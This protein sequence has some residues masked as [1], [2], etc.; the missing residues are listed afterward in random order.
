M[1]EYRVASWISLCQSSAGRATLYS[2][3]AG[4]LVSSL[5]PNGSSCRAANWLNH[6]TKTQISLLSMLQTLLQMMYRRWIVTFHLHHPNAYDSLAA[7][8]SKSSHSSECLA[9]LT[10]ENISPKIGAKKKVGAR[11][12]TLFHIFGYVKILHCFALFCYII[13]HRPDI[14]LS[15]RQIWI[16]FFFSPKNM[17]V[18]IFTLEKLWG[19][20]KLQG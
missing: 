4:E 17:V 8:L 2:S 5:A 20:K 16:V 10:C 9:N 6:Q 18:Q 7:K 1:E 12:S 13:Y 15:F 19:E 14:S 3:T 11:W